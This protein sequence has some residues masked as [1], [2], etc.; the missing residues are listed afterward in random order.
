MFVT[1]VIF[2][3]CFASTNLERKYATHGVTISSPLEVETTHQG[4]AMREIKKS[5]SKLEGE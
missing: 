3:A 1:G 5:N 4:K 2:M